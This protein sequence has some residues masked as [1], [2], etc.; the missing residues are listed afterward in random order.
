MKTPIWELSA[1]HLVTWLL[2]NTEAKPIDLWT[3]TLLNGTVL[4]YSGA[5]VAITVNGDTYSLGPKFR[6]T[7]TS[8]RMGVSVDSMA[9]QV[10]ATDADTLNGV[11]ILR[12]IAQSALQGA[13]V[14]VMWCFLDADNAPQGI[15][16][17][18]GGRVGDVP[19]SN[20]YQVTFNVRSWSALL[21]VMVPGDVYQAGCR[22]QLFG[23]RCKLSEA[24][25]TV[26]GTVASATGDRRTI[27]STSAAVIAKP[28][29]WATLG[30]LRFTTGPNT[31]LSRPVRVH[32]LSGSTAT[33]TAIYP[34]QLPISVGNA[35]QL[36]AGCDKTRAMCGSAKFLNIVNFRGE[37]FVPPPETVA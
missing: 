9:V 35:F 20:R 27:T 8:Q 24:A 12:A 15:V 6:R 37:S 34:F 7:R 18:F 23:P 21:D 36:I 17:G 30:T 5:D 10:V 29:G 1:G 14:A 19:S 32:S 11:P 26:A 2:A 25:F 31:G 16:G 3:I 22:N 4:R 28:T 13:K 33:I